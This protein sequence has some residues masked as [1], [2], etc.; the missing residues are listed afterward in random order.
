MS[1]GWRDSL[2]VGVGYWN[3]KEWARLFSEGQFEVIV[4]PLRHQS[5]NVIF[6]SKTVRK[7]GS[8]SHVRLFCSG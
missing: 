7:E 1:V 5:R 6:K 8:R 4:A 3:I 2:G